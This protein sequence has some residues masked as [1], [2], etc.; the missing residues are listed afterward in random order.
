MA[1]IIDKNTKVIVQGITG[2]QGSFHTKEMLSFGTQIVAGT[3]PGK[4]GLVVEGVPVFNSVEEAIEKTKANASV[5]FVP[6]PYTKE[7]AF[8]AIEAGIKVL[9]IITE[10][11]PV[12][13]AL[14]IVNLAKKRETIILGPNTFGICSSGQCKIGIPPN[15]IFTPG[16]VGVVSRSGTLT[17]EI[18]SSLTNK[19]IGQTTC[20]GLGGDRVVGLSFIDILRKFEED[21]L[22]K[23]VV[24]VGEI[25]GSQEEEASEF[26]KSMKKPVVAYIAGKS[27][28]PGKRMGHAGAIIER[29]KGAFAS[30]VQALT[31][32]GAMVAELPSQ[33]VDFVEQILIKT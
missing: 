20:L 22:T 32:A 10:K 13:D 17:Y 21:S 12:H 11:V 19:G 27:S 23:V 16:N 18:V 15:S 31:A 33:V 25:G 24:M 28:P 30:K 6:G 26:I 7:A 29:G 4:G 8:E 3:T 9:V 2:K 5:I 1:I 14:N